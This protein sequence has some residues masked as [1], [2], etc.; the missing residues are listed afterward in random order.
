M[1]S[2]KDISHLASDHIDNNLPFMM[3][4]KVKMQLFMCK[5][6]QNFMSQFKKTINMVQQVKPMPSS[7]APKKEAIDFQVQ[8]LLK[9]RQ[10]IKSDNIDN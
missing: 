9:A 5:N 3:K 6:C 2:C 8:A 10:T 4:M 1:L 7:V